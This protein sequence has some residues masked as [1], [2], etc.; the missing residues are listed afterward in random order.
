[1]NSQQIYNLIIGSVLQTTEFRF[2]CKL[3]NTYSTELSDRH[4]SPLFAASLTYNILIPEGYK[5]DLWDNNSKE[6]FVHLWLLNSLDIDM[7]FLNS[8]LHTN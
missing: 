3:S 1:M 6:S 2:K 7:S 4:V 8:D 5:T